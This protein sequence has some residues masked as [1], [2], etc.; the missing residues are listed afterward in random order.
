MK[1]GARAATRDYMLGFGCSMSDDYYSSGRP[2]DCQSAW[3]WKEKVNRCLDCAG[4][5][6]TCTVALVGLVA[7]KEE[8]RRDETPHMSP[9]EDGRVRS[10]EREKQSW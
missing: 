6:P 8:M 7:L 9:M 5:N 2:V 3:F 10:E 1:A 4:L